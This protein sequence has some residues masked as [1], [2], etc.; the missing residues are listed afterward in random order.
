MNAP[1]IPTS[2]QNKVYTGAD[3][4]EKMIAEKPGNVM[5]TAGNNGVKSRV[6]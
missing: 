6:Y 3:F 2:W 1:R 5:V 4:L